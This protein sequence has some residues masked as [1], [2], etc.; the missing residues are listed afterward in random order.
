MRLDRFIANNTF[1]SRKEVSKIIRKK[2][3]KVNNL[4]VTDGA[5]LIDIKIDEVKIDDL[6]IT[7]NQFVYL[8]LNK[9][10]DYICSSSNNEGNS[11]LN[12]I[13]ENK[14]KNLHIVG[15]LDKDTT[16]LILITNDGQFTHKIKSKKY[17]I[18]KEYEVILEKEFTNK[19]LEELQ[20]DIFLDGKKLKPFQI[21][22]I[23]KNCLNI[24]LIE[25]KYHQ[26]KRIFEIVKNPVIELKRIRIGNIKIHDLNLN[27][28]EYKEID[29]I[30]YGMK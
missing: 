22:N 30:I 25:G 5:Y 9:P 3:V 14:W 13:D 16:G 20:T 17:C 18:E 2:I 10:K 12:L 15:R 7:N 4:I 27:E 19:M 6:V 1:Y 8:V 21:F 29:P 26:I 28:G 24:I 23:N 11:I